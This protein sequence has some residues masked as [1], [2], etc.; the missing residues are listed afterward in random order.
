MPLFSRKK[1][2]LKKNDKPLTNGNAVSKPKWEDAWQRTRVDPEEVVELLHCCTAEIKS[3]ALD[4]PFLLLPFR[5]SSDPSAAKTFIRNFFFPVVERQKLTGHVL[6]KELRMTEVMVIVAVMKWCWARLPGGIV[7]WEAYQGFKVGEKDSRYARNSFSTFIP[8]GVD[9]KARVQ[10]IVDYFDL[11]A[12]LAAHG[13]TNGLGGHKLSRFGGWWAFEHYD[14]GKGF[15]AGYKLWNNAANA[16]SHLFFAYLRGQTPEPGSTNGILDLPRSLQQLV[17]SVEYPPRSIFI[18]NDTTKVVMIVDVVSPTPFA[19]LRRAKQFEYRDDDMALQHFAAF[20]D[21][22]DALTEE[23]RRVLRAIS[24]TNQSHVSDAATSTSLKDPSWSRFEDIGFG[25]AFGDNNEDA[26]FSKSRSSTAQGLHSTSRSGVTDLNR[27]TTPSWADFLSSGFTDENGNKASAPVLLPPDKALPPMTTV[28][29][30]QSSQS[31]RRDLDTSRLEPGE[32][33]SIAKI[34]L[35]DAFWWVWISSLAGEEPVS[36]KAAFGRCALIET[37]LLGGQWMVMEEQVKGAA[38]EPAPGAY[39]AERK[40]FFSFTKKGRLNRRRSALKKS[41]LVDDKPLDPS[42]RMTLDQDRQARIQHAAAELA[43]KNKEE[44]LQA[45]NQRRG[46]TDENASVKTTS[47]FTLGPLIK[48]EASPALQWAKQ[49]D[50]KAIREQYLG[51]QLAGKGSTDFLTLPSG[52]LSIKRS[53]STLSSSKDLPLTPENFVTP[54]QEI[55]FTLQ[56]E[57]KPVAEYPVSPSPIQEQTVT[58]EQPVPV[59]AANTIPVEPAIVAPVQH[60]IDATLTQKNPSVTDLSVAQS[61]TS[62]ESKRSNKS[63]R[64]KLNTEKNRLKK[65]GFN[66]PPPVG[67]N[68]NAGMKKLFGTLR[69]TKGPSNNKLSPEVEDEDPAIAAARRALEGK[70]PQPGDGPVSPPLSPNHFAKLQNAAKKPSEMA[71]SSE[72][73]QIAESTTTAPEPVVSTRTIDAQSHEPV[74]ELQQ[75]QNHEPE[76]VDSAPYVNG[77]AVNLHDRR[78]D[79][80]EDLSQVDSHERAQ[81]AHEFSRFDQ[82]PLVDQPAFAPADAEQEDEYEQNEAPAFEPPHRPQHTSVYSAVTMQTE[83]TDE[84]FQVDP[85]Q[86]M[87]AHDRWAQIRR[88]AAERAARASDDHARSRTETR[89]TDDGETS[90]E[91]TI[92]SRVA[93]IKARVAELTGNMD[94]A[95]R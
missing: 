6:T 87:S 34:E 38:P 32:L 11:L 68:K 23:C 50:K 49:Y 3:R 53:A 86:N 1:D 24:S 92:E 88:N 13:K 33:A 66:A 30:G 79:N 28:P 35:D 18:A 8:L 46:R 94:A 10:I 76:K 59:V 65:L 41:P 40:S 44:Q 80:F 89:T 73:E 48:D 58:Q 47:V 7:T 52:G 36:R 75:S 74:P 43:R 27:P 72:P 77:S 16:T 51:N 78:L 62:N 70:P 95:R 64:E 29:R 12:A 60:S 42:N 15:D 31:H 37:S 54:S 61:K 14:T 26:L 22:V 84:D 2:K 45:L 63:D 5:P 56:T 82:G 9:S 39:V 55:P 91:E 25:S 57:S 4:V 85:M 93:R 90:G 81:A 19:L 20:E 67:T 71:T 83:A 21:P 69:K 17:D